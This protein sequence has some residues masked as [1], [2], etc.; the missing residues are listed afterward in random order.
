[1]STAIGAGCPVQVPQWHGHCIWKRGRIS[2]FFLTTPFRRPCAAMCPA[3]AQ[4]S[5]DGIANLPR[6]ALRC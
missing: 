5:S 3:S 4:S 6:V 1:M 2:M